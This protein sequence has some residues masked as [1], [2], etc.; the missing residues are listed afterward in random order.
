VKKG[1]MTLLKVH[2]FL[3]TESKDLEVDKNAGEI[4]QKINLK[5]VPVT[6]KRILINS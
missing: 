2:N 5:T 4:I 1:N 6:S 3:V